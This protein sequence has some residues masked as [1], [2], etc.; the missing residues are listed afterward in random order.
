MTIM[1][2]HEFTFTRLARTVASE[3]YVI[4]NSKGRVGHL[5]IHIQSAV[6][7]N[8]V[9]EQNLKEEVIEALITEI[10]Q[11]V[12][13]GI[14]PREDFIFTVF[15]GKEVGYYSDIV[16]E[17]PYDPVKRGDVAQLSDM[18]QKV[19]GRHQY[20]KG[21]L[22]ELVVREFFESLRYTAKK[23]SSELDQMKIDV[24]AQNSKEIIY[25][26]VKLGQISSSQIKNVLRSVSGIKTRS[27]KAKTVAFVASTYPNN[28]EI[29]RRDLEQQ[30][31]IPIWYIHTYQV[32][33][34]LPEYKKTIGGNDE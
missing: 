15:K 10:D 18:L 5:D 25:I 28:S 14:E 21:Q 20:A 30:Y 23:A 33:S 3:S 8:L 34:L 7:G 9:I 11:T 26:Q 32:I 31:G 12:V 13:S 1:K 17:S 16:E 19:L 27:K 2:E 22:N 24:V 29:L 6:H 4:F